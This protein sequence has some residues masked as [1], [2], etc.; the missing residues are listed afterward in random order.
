MLNWFADALVY[1]EAVNELRP[2]VVAD[3][4]SLATCATVQ[5]WCEWCG[6]STTFHVPSESM[7]G[8]RPN[9]REGMRCAHCRLTNRQRLVGCAM[10]ESVATS[11]SRI[12]LLEQ[13]SRL[14]R[15]VKR[16]YPN[17]VGSEFLGSDKRLGSTYIWRSSVL[18]FRYTKHEDITQL[19]YASNSLD[20]I[21]HS[22]VL[23]HVYDYQAALCE[24]FRVLKPGGALLFTVPFFHENAVSL[25][26]GKPNSDGSIWH[27]APPEYHGDG[28]TRT[29]I[30]TFHSF[31]RDLMDDIRAIG[32]AQVSIGLWYAPTHG[33]TSANAADAAH[34]MLPMFFRALK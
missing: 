17:T 18:R 32:F 15:L 1:A 19:S 4:A 8:S 11:R 27:F 5:G 30:Y 26:R 3:E 10:R 20:L 2:V 28:L 13:T 23:E 22:D 31:G 34:D 25:L 7:F 12:A 21:A 16:R 29:G 14:Y 33:F 6:R 24:C 9:M